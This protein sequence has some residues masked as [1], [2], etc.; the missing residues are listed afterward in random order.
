MNYDLYSNQASLL[1]AI[2]KTTSDLPDHDRKQYVLQTMRVMLTEYEKK[3]NTLHT[4]TS[5]HPAYKSAEYWLTVG[6]GRDLV[7][8][9]TQL[10]K[11]F[12]LELS[13]N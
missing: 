11:S 1:H 12:L 7:T 5:A 2:V 8:Y 13:K 4:H 3:I 9:F 6:E 10:Y